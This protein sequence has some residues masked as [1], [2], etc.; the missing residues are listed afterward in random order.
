MKLTCNINCASRTR[1]SVYFGRN[2]AIRQHSL[3]VLRSS[4][5]SL[6]NLSKFLFRGAGK[7]PS[8]RFCLQNTL[9]LTLLLSVGCASTQG[10]ETVSGK[11]VQ[12]DSK[13]NLT[14]LLVSQ[15]VDSHLYRAIVTINMIDRGGTTHAYEFLL[16]KSITGKRYLYNQ[17]GT[18]P[19]EHNFTS[20]NGEI[21]WIWVGEGHHPDQ[22]FDT[23]NITE[24]PMQ[25][26]R[27]DIEG[28]GIKSGM[29]DGLIPDYEAKARMTGICAIQALNHQ[30]QLSK[31][32]GNKLLWHSLLHVRYNKDG[33]EVGHTYCVFTLEGQ[34]GLFAYDYTGTHKIVSES[35]GALAVGMKLKNFVTSAKYDE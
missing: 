32:Y 2:R 20:G 22:T 9:F 18:I 35:Y 24:C 15:A 12:Y 23:V 14:V 26:T 3:G 7:W 29:K 11:R 27:G 4:N 34:K 10:V 1:R 33:K 21:N 17:D 5:F 8:L 30:A 13:N 31:L 16:V 25:Q 28:S 19:L 6:S